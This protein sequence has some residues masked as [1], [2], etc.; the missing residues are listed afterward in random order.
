MVCAPQCSCAPGAG[1]RYFLLSTIFFFAVAPHLPAWAKSLLCPVVSFM[2][3]VRADEESL[4]AGPQPTAAPS[5][6]AFS[7][8][9][10][11]LSLF[12]SLPAFE[13]FVSYLE[14]L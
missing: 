1:P 4:W 9:H 11:L 2:G 8:P 10:P 6:L 12:L 14:Q 7:S 3:K 13:T 5:Q